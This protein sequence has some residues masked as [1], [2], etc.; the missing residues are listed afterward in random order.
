MHSEKLSIEEILY[1]ISR[2]EKNH[3][4]TL[5]GYLLKNKMALEALRSKKWDK[6]A[7]YYNGK[8]YMKNKYDILIKEI[9]EK[10]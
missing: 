9:Y 6:F 4:I 7:L 8:Q 10:L 5:K 2:S 3:L 1:E